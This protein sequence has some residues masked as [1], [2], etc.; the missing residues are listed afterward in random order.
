[1]VRPFSLNLD[2]LMLESFFREAKRGK[3]AYGGGVFWDNPCENTMQ[4]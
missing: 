4:F 3:Q 1:M 2:G